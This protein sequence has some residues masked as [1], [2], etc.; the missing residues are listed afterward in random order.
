MVIVVPFFDGVGNPPDGAVGY[1]TDGAD[2]VS[3]E[4]PPVGTAGVAGIVV[5]GGT[6]SDELCTGATVVDCSV[7]A[8]AELGG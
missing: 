5:T 3:M 2:P 1:G 8:G 4:M 6:E 7:V